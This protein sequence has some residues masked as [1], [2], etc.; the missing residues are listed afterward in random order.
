MQTDFIPQGTVNQSATNSSAETVAIKATGGPAKVMVTAP[1]GNPLMFVKFG[2]STDTASAS[3]DTPILAGS[4]QSF[5]MTAGQT[6]ASV[7]S[8]T[9]S[10]GT[11]YFTLVGEP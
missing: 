4:V 10:S 2:S 3:T 11:L 8:N 7:I 9:S 5:L 1:T 6:N